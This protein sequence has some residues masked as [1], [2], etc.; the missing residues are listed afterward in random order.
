MATYKQCLISLFVDILQ[1]ISAVEGAKVK[2]REKGIEIAKDFVRIVKLR[3]ARGWLF[4]R[5]LFQCY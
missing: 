5:A 3:P 2:I 4:F 1:D